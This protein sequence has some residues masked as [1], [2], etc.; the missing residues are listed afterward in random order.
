MD[1]MLL[2]LPGLFII[3]LVIAMVCVAPNVKR[4][5]QISEGRILQKTHWVENEES[6]TIPAVMHHT[7][8]SSQNVSL[9]LKIRYSEAW[10]VRVR[11]RLRT[12]SF[13][14]S[15]EIY[16]KVEMGQWFRFEEHMGSRKRPKQEITEYTLKR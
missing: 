4:R 3:F 13:Y 7:G 14:L 9:P 8:K 1:M 10:E 5:F 2:L 16:D 11:N 6:P 12:T 15:K